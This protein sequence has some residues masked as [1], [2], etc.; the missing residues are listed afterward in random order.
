[1]TETFADEL[2]KATWSD[3]DG[4]EHTPYLDALMRGQ[5]S[6][7]GY[8]EMVAQHYF[9]YVALEAAAQSLADDPIAGAFVRPE[10]ERVPALERDLEFL[11]GPDWR[12][13]ITPSKSTLTYVARIN[14]VADWPEGFI[15]HHYTRYLGDLSG[16]QVIR[17][18]AE[19]TYEFKDEL[20]TSFY[21]F[22]EIPDL[23][24]FKMGY[25]DWL[26]ALDLSE[27][28]RKRMINETLLAYQL[29]TEVLVEIGKQLP[30]YLV[31]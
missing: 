15:A 20:G 23:K 18:I 4:A 25:R 6:Q 27:T 29:N 22:P 3:H 8:A 19:R 13:A 7:A 9:A 10:L 12:E 5:L 30:T 11:Y 24:A 1:M 14:Q 16:G 17:K 31:A 21:L 28:Q 26:N 2:R